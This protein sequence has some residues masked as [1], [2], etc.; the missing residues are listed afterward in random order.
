MFECRPNDWKSG[1]TRQWR[2]ALNC[3]VVAIAT[4]RFSVPLCWRM[5]TAMQKWA[6][7]ECCVT[8]NLMNVCCCVC[9]SRCR[10]KKRLV[11]WCLWHRTTR[12]KRQWRWP[13]IQFLVCNCEYF[14]CMHKRF[15]W[16]GSL[17]CCWLQGRVHIKH[18][19][20][21][22]CVWKVRGWRRR[23]QRCAVVARRQVCDWIHWCVNNVQNVIN[24]FNCSQPYGGVKD[25]G[26]GREGL[27]F[28]LIFFFFCQ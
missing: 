27:V 4:M 9:V 2:T 8:I 17:L 10:R 15:D 18:S 20:S 7:G 28:F 14:C 13:T 16:Y 25:S 22:V 11:R 12:L 5:W 6:C 23:D 1:W 3:C 24:L 19:Q 21:A 26:L